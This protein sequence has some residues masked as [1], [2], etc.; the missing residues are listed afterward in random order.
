ML[1]TSRAQG[2]TNS[3]D[4]A[5]HGRKSV[6][7][8]DVTGANGGRHDDRERRSRCSRAWRRVAEIISNRF[9]LAGGDGPGRLEDRVVD[10]LADPEAGERL[11]RLARML[12]VGAA[13]IVTIAGAVL[14][15]HP[16]VVTAFASSGGT[17]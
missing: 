9:D 17:R 6:S 5:K 3:T 16:D 14:L 4:A 15:V 12:I 2:E 7:M 11:L 13:L 10:L 1:T 8:K